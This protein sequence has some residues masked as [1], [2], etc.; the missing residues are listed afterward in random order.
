M[1]PSTEKTIWQ[2]RAEK[3][4]RSLIGREAQLR[5]FRRSNLAKDTTGRIVLHTRLA[6]RRYSGKLGDGA[7]IERKRHLLPLR[8]D[9]KWLRGGA[10]DATRLSQLSSE[11]FAGLRRRLHKVHTRKR[12]RAFVA[13]STPAERRR[14][15]S[16][17][18][19]TA[20]RW[21]RSPS[22]TSDVLRLL[23]CQNA[24][25]YW[26]C[27][28]L[29]SLCPT[30]RPRRSPSLTAMAA[31]GIEVIREPLLRLWDR[32]LILQLPRAH[33]SGKPFRHRHHTH[34]GL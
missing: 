15:S 33:R 7:G 8:N 14:Q 26:R 2:S 19:N 1:P 5:H 6:R 12:S 21:T 32:F 11:G 16:S 4:T 25:Q 9:A 20:P 13:S 17:S 18:P 29:R 28:T 24:Q 30:C 31:F 23:H 10:N 3:K 34:R 27:F 22:Q